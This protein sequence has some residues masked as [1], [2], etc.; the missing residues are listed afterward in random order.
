MNPYLIKVALRGKGG[1]GKSTPP[2][3]KLLL[4]MRTSYRLAVFATRMVAGM[5]SP[6]ICCAADAGENAGR[7]LWNRPVAVYSILGCDRVAQTQA[8]QPRGITPRLELEVRC[9]KVH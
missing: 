9:D 2:P 5:I 7:D 4:R 3:R 8:G 1:S 6:P